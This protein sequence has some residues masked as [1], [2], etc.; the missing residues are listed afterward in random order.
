MVFAVYSGFLHQLQ[1]ASTK[2][3]QYGRKS[4][5]KSKLHISLISTFILSLARVSW[6]WMPIWSSYNWLVTKKPQYGRISDEKT[7]F[8]IP[9][10]SSTLILSLALVSWSWMPICSANF[11]ASDVKTTLLSGSSSLLPTENTNRVLKIRG[12]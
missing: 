1:L 12:M 11:W 2:K 8:Q 3:P 7:K 9:L 6:S 10:T 5:E 4:D